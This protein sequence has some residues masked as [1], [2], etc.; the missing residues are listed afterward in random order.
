MT[1]PGV[2][3]RRRPFPPT[4]HPPPS[5][6]SISPPKFV[7]CHQPSAISYQPSAI[8]HQPSAISHQPSA[9]SHQPSAISYQPSAIIAMIPH[10]TILAQRDSYHTPDD[11]K[12]SMLPPTLAFYLDTVRVVFRASH[13]AKHGRYGE[14]EWVDSS[15]DIINALEH[16]GCRLHIEGMEHLR[17]LHGPAVFV[18]NHMST[19]ET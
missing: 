5:S 8:S 2:P 18:A 6:F 11:R 17:G 9:I 19:L 7:I 4:T 3:T 1:T 13:A 15:L 14:A 12:P 16:A 10:G